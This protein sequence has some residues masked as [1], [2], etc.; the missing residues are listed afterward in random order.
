MAFRMSWMASSGQG[1][2]LSG[3]REVIWVQER[4]ENWARRWERCGGRGAG[5][6][7]S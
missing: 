6:L 4:L 7:V 2:W 3:G 5:V 1:G